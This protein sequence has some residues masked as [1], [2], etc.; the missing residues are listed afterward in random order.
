[1]FALTPGSAAPPQNNQLPGQDPPNNQRLFRPKMPQR[2]RRLHPLLGGLAHGRCQPTY[3]LF[4][5]TASPGTRCH[6]RHNLCRPTIGLTHA[7][8]ACKAPSIENY[9][10]ARST[11]ASRPES[12]VGRK[13]CWADF[14]TTQLRV[15]IAFITI[16]NNSCGLFVVP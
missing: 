10:K 7:A 5:N 12:S 15:T 4:Y 9:L 14:L 2:W 3:H 11:S 16:G 1:V 6:Y 13:R 8:S